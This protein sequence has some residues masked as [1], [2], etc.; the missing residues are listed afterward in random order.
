MAYF[1]PI[2]RALASEKMEADKP[3]ND[4]YANKTLLLALQKIPPTLTSPGFPVLAPST[5]NFTQ[6]LLGFFQNTSLKVKTFV[7]K[8]SPKNSDSL[9]ESYPYEGSI[10]DSYKC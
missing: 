1:K 9:L 8:E 3:R 5:F 7:E 6:E 2:Q 10:C 4:A